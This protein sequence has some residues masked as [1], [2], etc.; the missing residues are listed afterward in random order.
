MLSSTKLGFTNRGTTTL[1]NIKYR[2][3]NTQFIREEKC[4]Q[5]CV[6]VI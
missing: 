6:C 4:A 1:S 5:I 2:R 3:A